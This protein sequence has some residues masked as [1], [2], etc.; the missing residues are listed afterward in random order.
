MSVRV[1]STEVEEN[2]W[3]FLGSR[4]SNW[5]VQVDVVE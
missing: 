5:M 4:G 2:E 1:R 3:V